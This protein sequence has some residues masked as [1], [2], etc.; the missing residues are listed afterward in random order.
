VARTPL[1][2]GWTGKGVTIREIE[3][4]LSAL[5]EAARIGQDAGNLRTNVM[6]HI[7]WVPQE[8]LEAATDTL[9]GLAERHP[10]RTILLVPEPDAEEDRLDAEVSLRCFSLAGESS[11]PVCSEV[12]ELHLRGRRSLAP[13]SIVEPLLVADLTVFLRWRGL[14]PFGADEFEQLVRV[15]DRLVVDSREWPTLPESFLQLAAVFGRIAVSD[16][17]WARTLPWRSALA[18]LWPRIGEAR[19]L[20]VA[21][22]RAE[23]LLLGG[24]LRSRLGREIALVHEGR[25]EL[26]RVAADGEAVRPARGED[27]TP[28]DLLS[29]ELDNFGREPVYEEAVH[30]AAQLRS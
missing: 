10:S 29:A 30:A 24:W 27:P 4:Q 22:P 16:I 2:D 1:T 19:E 15:A 7:A 13:A 21:G 9:A 14:P 23:A 17:A 26:V 6:T 8:W 25:E 12:I 11:G 20:E 3:G 5:R 28:S 18:A